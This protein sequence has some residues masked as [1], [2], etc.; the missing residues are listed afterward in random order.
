MDTEMIL[1]AIA[2]AHP[3]FHVCGDVVRT[4]LGWCVERNKHV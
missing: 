2:R 4:K 3:R 1:A